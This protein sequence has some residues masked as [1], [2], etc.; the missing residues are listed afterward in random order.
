MQEADTMADN[1]DPPPLF[2]T[3]DI[4]SKLD[5]D[6][7]DV[8]DLFASTVSSVPQSKSLFNGSS[9]SQTS[10]VQNQSQSL[11]ESA[12]PEQ[13]SSQEHSRSL[14]Q[15]TQSLEEVE[16]ESYDQFLEISVTEPQ[17]VGDGMGSYIA[18]KVLTKTNMPLFRKNQFI[19]M[20][21]FSDFLGLH[22]KLVEK[23]L[24][25]GRIIPPAPEKNILS[26]TKIKISNQGEPGAPSEFIERRR[27][28]LER[29]MVRTAAHPILS[30]D[31]D[32][33]EFL[34]ADIEL[35]RATNTSALSSA[36][37]LRL[38]NKVGETVNKITFKMEENDPN[39]V[40]ISKCMQESKLV[41][42]SHNAIII[43]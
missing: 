43:F 19:V 4:T 14:L 16:T 12:A 1:R 7:D 17:K 39:Q 24:R 8:E 13:E 28:A 3:V 5:D 23:Y 26:T 40:S 34:E 32:F 9:E 31:P 35:P 38:F 18:Y 37:V 2:D 36:G 27:A 21:R 22:E 11:Y 25:A 6:E 30:V 15:S 33:R 41:H 20:R 10:Q 29:F 42:Y